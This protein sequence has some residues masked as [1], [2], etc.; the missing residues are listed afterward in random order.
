MDLEA[1]KCV[2]DVMSNFDQTIE[3]GS[4]DRLAEPN[5]Y[6]DY[7]GENFMGYVYKDEDGYHCIV[8]Q[9]HKHVNTV[10]P[11]SSLEVLMKEVSRKYGYE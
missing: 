10:G 3:P 11:R 2:G 8:Y 6:G 5:T 9:Y 1:S 7:H 4:E